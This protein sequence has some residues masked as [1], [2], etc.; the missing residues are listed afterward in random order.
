MVADRE[1][2]V[3]IGLEYFVDEGDHLWNMKDEDLIQMGIKEASEIGFIQPEDFLDG[4]AIR[5]PK[6]YPAYFGTYDQIPVLQ[7]YVM[8][9]KNLF[10]IGRNG[11]H[12][13]NNQDHSMLVKRDPPT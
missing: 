13:Y 10:L 2:T 7:D 5:M 1:N 12:R 11:M 4:C 6:A 3:W 8:K 9:F